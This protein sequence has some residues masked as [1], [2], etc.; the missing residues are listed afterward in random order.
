[1]AL[2][3]SDNEA[4]ARAASQKASYLLNK[5]NLER[6]R[7]DIEADPVHYILIS[8]KKKR[9][10]SLE[11]NMAA[12]L[13][14]YYFVTVVLTS[15]YD[16]K[17]CQ[18]YKSLTLI[19]KKA[20]L[21]VAEYAYHFLRDSGERLW[22]SYRK[23]NKINRGRPMFDHGYKQGLVENHEKALRNAC[24]DV[25]ESMLPKIISRELVEKSKMDLSAETG[26]LFGR[27]SYRSTKISGSRATYE[28]GIENGRKTFVN[29]SVVR[30]HAGEQKYLQ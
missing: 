9:M 4:E 24:E 1:M 6:S 28:A 20:S 25:S 5:Y 23:E 29:K 30:G 22:Q 21:E 8:H 27:L 12:I 26:R 19:G 17:T 7:R 18:E 3:T 10:S 15:T 2:G 11:K 16:P 14:K 13:N